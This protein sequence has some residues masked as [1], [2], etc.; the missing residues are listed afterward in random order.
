[1]KDSY[2]KL[3]NAFASRFRPNHFTDYSHCNEC[4]EHNEALCAKDND[5]ITF[6]DVGNISYSPI[7]FISISGFLYYLPGLA[8]LASGTGDEYF[9]DTFLIY[10]DNNERRMAL[11]REERQALAEYLIHLKDI[12]L[13]SIQENLDEEDLDELIQWLK[14]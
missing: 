3:R 12:L 9:L 2:K 14:T 13:Q 4:F 7:S 5:L 11:S 1:M 10:L 8:R 6:K